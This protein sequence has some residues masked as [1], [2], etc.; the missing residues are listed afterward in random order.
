LI[1]RVVK[2]NKPDRQGKACLQAIKM[3]KP[4]DATSPVYMSVFRQ[5]LTLA[6]VD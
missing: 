1:P 5:S 2:E 6:N 4:N 3:A